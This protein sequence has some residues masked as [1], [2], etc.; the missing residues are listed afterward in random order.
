MED[1]AG[2]AALQ[3][4]QAQRGVHARVLDGEPDQPSPDPP[5]GIHFAGEGDRLPNYL[6]LGQGVLFN[7]P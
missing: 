4:E 7:H 3:L 6:H 2:G 1:H 5:D